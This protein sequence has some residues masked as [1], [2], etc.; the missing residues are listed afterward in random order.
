MM[1]QHIAPLLWILGGI[2]FCIFL[3]SAST[4]LPLVKHLLFY[5][6]FLIIDAGCLARTLTNRH[7]NSSQS[8]FGL[9]LVGV[10]LFFLL[11]AVSFTRAVLGDILS[12]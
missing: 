7:V 6:S 8:N 2:V 12:E 1:K 5:G 11:I 4:A 10:I 9:K 3:V